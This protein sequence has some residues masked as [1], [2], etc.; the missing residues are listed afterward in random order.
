MSPPLLPLWNSALSIF[1][2]YLTRSPILLLRNPD[3]DKPGIE[4]RRN[5]DPERNRPKDGD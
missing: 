2:G 5:C 4:K 3:D 1:S